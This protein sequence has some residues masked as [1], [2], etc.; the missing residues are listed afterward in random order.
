MSIDV[1][2]GCSALFFNL[3]IQTTQAV[4]QLDKAH[5]SGSQ[6]LSMAQPIQFLN[7]LVNED[8]LKPDSS[9]SVS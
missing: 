8:F 4:Q 3:E 1:D 6:V 7:Q 5:I 9:S 2:I